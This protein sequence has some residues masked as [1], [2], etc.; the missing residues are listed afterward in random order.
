MARER[1]KQ[2]KKRKKKKNL[3]KRKKYTNRSF[4]LSID[5]S[6]HNSCDH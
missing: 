6:I 5:L 4:Y 2:K 1:W 3:I